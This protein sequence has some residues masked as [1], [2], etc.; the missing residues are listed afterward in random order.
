MWLTWLLIGG[1]LVAQPVTLQ[2]RL[3]DEQVAR[4]IA[5][6]DK[7]RDPYVCIGRTA[8]GEFTVCLQGPEQRIGLEVALT[9]QA[10]R[11]L[12]VADVSAEV[13]AQTWT[14]VVRPNQPALVDGR[15]VR[16]PLAEDLR[17]QLRGHPEVSVRPLTATQVP[18]AWDNAIGVTLNGQGLTATFD[19]PTLP[20]G[21]LDVV[22]TV[23]GAI[24]RRY[25][26]SQS[27]RAQI[28]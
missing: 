20:A 13:R 24:D 18:V 12:L 3:T 25:V 28:R 7:L 17:L 8:A 1:L 6:A 15:P 10:H 9:K 4:A 5:R 27:A 22:I 26:L 23:E 16:T 19:A 11:R 14:M 2:G 21:D